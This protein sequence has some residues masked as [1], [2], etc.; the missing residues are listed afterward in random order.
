MLSPSRFWPTASFMDCPSC[1]NKAKEQGPD[2]IICGTCGDLS[3]VDG[4]WIPTEAGPPGSVPVEQKP[5]VG[6]EP[7][8]PEPPP[9][10]PPEPVVADDQ[11]D[12]DKKWLVKV[13]LG[14]GS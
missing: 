7:P 9:E 5:P 13:D 11:D 14:A 6:Q 1:S 12:E 3:R 10:P 2:R 8:I 4:E